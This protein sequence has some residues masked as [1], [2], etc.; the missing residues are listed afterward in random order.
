MYNMFLKILKYTIIILFF[1]I[2]TKWII[3]IIPSNVTK[4]TIIKPI[5][6]NQ[7]KK[8]KP[9]K[10]ISI[11]EVELAVSLKKLEPQIKYE[12]KIT[13]DSI[14][15]YIDKTLGQYNRIAIYNL[16]KQ[17]GFL[18][19]IF[20]WDTG[21]EMVER[22]MR[23]W[24][25]NSKTRDYLDNLAV[26]TVSFFSDKK[27]K[28]FN[29]YLKDSDNEV[30]FVEQKFKS[31]V[32]SQEKLDHEIQ[33]IISYTKQ[34]LEHFNKVV[35]L[36]AIDDLNE[37]IK[38]LHKQYYDSNITINNYEL[39]WGKYL[40]QHAIT[41]GVETSAFSGIG[42]VVG[43]VVAPKVATLLGP[44]VLCMVTSKTATILSA[45]LASSFSLVLA[46]VVDYLFN[47]G[48]KTLEYEDTKQNFKSIITQTMNEVNS[49]VYT[50]I[51]TVLIN[52]KNEVFTEL[53][54]KT[55]I[56]IKQKSD[57]M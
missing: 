56:L 51:N 40:T 45:K 21:F 15:D 16:T 47:A 2:I 25:T 24:S 46:P 11:K 38:S 31:M 3:N 6:I 28:E 53:N 32:L 36:L 43:K 20:G 8:I 34:K 10:S 4:K 42:F 52:T 50:E 29:S 7:T 33:K 37:Q 44:K 9:K 57:I 5:E 19:W 41:L 22:K 1:I 27:A 17:D 39:P 49:S 23:S 55:T 54:K 14:Y 18:E 35:I 30:E 26:T 13:Q 48:A 12:Y